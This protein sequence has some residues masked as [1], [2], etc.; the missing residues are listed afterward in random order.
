MES[1]RIYQNGSGQYTTKK[2]LP[3][4]G[5]ENTLDIISKSIV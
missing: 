1:F 5:K 2:S 3:A 4:A